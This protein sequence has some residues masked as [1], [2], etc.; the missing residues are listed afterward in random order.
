VEDHFRKRMYL[1]YIPDR[2]ECLGYKDMINRGST[3]LGN[4]PFAGN[5]LSNNE[6]ECC[7][8]DGVEE[9]EC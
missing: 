9:K 1:L 5:E 3:F 8:N 7:Y 6:R 2:E 4:I